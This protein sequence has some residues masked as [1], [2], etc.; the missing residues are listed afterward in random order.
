V[1]KH[2]STQLHS[3]GSQLLSALRQEYQVFMLYFR[4]FWQN[5][6]YYWQ[7]LTEIERYICRNHS[8]PWIPRIKLWKQI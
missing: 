1:Y 6:A 3:E 4:Q 5:E 2:S 8:V 7:D